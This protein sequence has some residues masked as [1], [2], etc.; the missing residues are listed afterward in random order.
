MDDF[1]YYGVA[2]L[3]ELS[4]YFLKNVLY[5]SISDSTALEK[6]GGNFVVVR[7]GGGYQ[8]E[9]GDSWKLDLQ[10]HDTSNGQFTRIESIHCLKTVPSHEQIIH[11]NNNREKKSNIIIHTAHVRQDQEDSRVSVACMCVGHMCM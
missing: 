3:I 10:F 4:C 6:K 2:H 1:I 8:R 9:R 5:Q 11:T 7:E